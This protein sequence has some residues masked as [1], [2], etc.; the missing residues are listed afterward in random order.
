M[1]L[2]VV[3]EENTATNAIHIVGVADN[4][5]SAGDIAAISMS[6]G[7]LYRAFSETYSY[8]ASLDRDCYVVYAKNNWVDSSKG[9]KEDPKRVFGK[10]YFPGERPASSDVKI[11]KTEDSATKKAATFANEILDPSYEHKDMVEGAFAKIR[12]NEAIY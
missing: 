12:V 3:F 1:Q 11:Y 8:T 10:M 4:E 7:R 2:Y 6:K 5:L 9:E